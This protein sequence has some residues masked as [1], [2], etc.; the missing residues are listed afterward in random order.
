[1]A[2]LPP[3]PILPAAEASLASRPE[4]LVA[5][6]EA[7]HGSAARIGEMAQIGPEATIP[8]FA[9]MLETAQPWQHKLAAQGLDDIAALLAS[10]L[11]AL[12]TLAA[13]GQDTAAPALALWREFH[14]AR[15][16]VLAALNPAIRG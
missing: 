1:M 3:E 14:A 10:G 7:L 2:S 6:W 4:A 13:R 12:G 16:A 11:A 8:A 5:Q 15:A 9:Q